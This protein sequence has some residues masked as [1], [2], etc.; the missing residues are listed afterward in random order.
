MERQG[1]STSGRR[2]VSRSSLAR[3][4]ARAPRLDCMLGSLFSR[5]RREKMKVRKMN[6][7]LS[8]LA[9]LFFRRTRAQ[10]FPARC[11][12]RA[13]LRRRRRRPCRRCL[14]LPARNSGQ[15]GGVPG[16]RRLCDNGALLLLRRWWRLERLR[17]RIRTLLLRRRHRAPLLSPPG[18]RPRRKR[19]T[20]R[21][22]RSSRRRRWR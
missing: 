6:F 17:S 16:E 3:S 9:F 14:P 22:T 8:L 11:V 4:Q 21:S 1:V 10:P 13:S 2:E 12:P 20:R 19:A 7:S 5:R 15:D 18:R